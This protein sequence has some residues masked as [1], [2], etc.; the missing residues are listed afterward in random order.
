MYL[1][2]LF[3]YYSFLLQY[4]EL[5]TFYTIVF[6]LLIAISSFDTYKLLVKVIV[7][8]FCNCKVIVKGA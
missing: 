8:R 2:L 7:E 4:F 3:Q 1:I 5:V 6:C